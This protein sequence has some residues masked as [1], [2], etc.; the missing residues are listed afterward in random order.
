MPESAEDKVA[1]EWVARVEREHSAAIAGIQKELA[2]TAQ[3]VSDLTQDV[4]SVTT[5]VD[6]L[7][8]RIAEDEKESA[9]YRMGQAF[10]NGRN[11]GIGMA[12]V[13]FVGA[14]GST[15]AAWLARV[16]GIGQ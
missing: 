16:F 4:A 3:M 11:M 12:I 8:A 14:I 15:V 10:T 1:R 13:F 5:S 7:A 2:V 6:R 9:A